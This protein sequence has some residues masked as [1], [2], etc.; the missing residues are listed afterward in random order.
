MFGIP[1]IQK[2]IVLAAVIALV[3]YGFKF[4]GRLQDQRKAEG[5]LGA[6]AARRPKRRSRTA[7]AEPA[8]QDAEDMVACP[9]CQAYVQARG[10]TRCD[11]SD[12]P[13]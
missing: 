9:V 2:L 13:Y 11:R 6:R 5:G 12:C 7:A 1:S 8:V 4:I 3:W 10:V